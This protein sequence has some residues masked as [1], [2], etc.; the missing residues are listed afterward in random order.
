MKTNHNYYS[1]VP[2]LGRDCKHWGGEYQ[3]ETVIPRGY[4]TL[5]LGI[6]NDEER[7]VVWHGEHCNKSCELAKIRKKIYDRALEASDNIHK[8]DKYKSIHTEIR[9]ASEAFDKIADEWRNMK[10]PFYE[11]I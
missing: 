7:L 10:C 8:S 6:W 11:R 2:C 5:G 1:N 3:E 4:D 9:K